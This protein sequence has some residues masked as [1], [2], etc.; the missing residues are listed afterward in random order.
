MSP[1]M[2]VRPRELASTARPSSEVRPNSRARR[3]ASSK[4]ERNAELPCNIC[5]EDTEI[6]AGIELGAHFL[7]LIAIG[8]KH[9]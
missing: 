7:S 9:R 8:E 4:V 1:T 3:D 2:L 5:S 6:G